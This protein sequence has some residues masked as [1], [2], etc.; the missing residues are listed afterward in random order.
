MPEGDLTSASSSRYLPDKT[1][2][3]NNLNEQE[4]NAVLDDSGLDLDEPV[5]DGTI[6]SILSES[7]VNF[8]SRNKKLRIQIYPD[9]CGR[10]LIG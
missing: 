7:G 3:R 5:P 1:A 9:T 10:G 2:G 4:S 6:L 8:V